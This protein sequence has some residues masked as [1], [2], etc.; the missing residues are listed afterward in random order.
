MTYQ[1]RGSADDVVSLISRLIASVEGANPEFRQYTHDVLGRVGNALLGQV[2]ENFTLKMHRQQGTDGETWVELAPATI[3]RKHLTASAGV[4]HDA[5]ERIART[6]RTI[7]ETV[8][9]RYAT[10]MDHGEARKR[11]ARAAA[12]W[13]AAE[14]RRVNDNLDPEAVDILRETGK[15]LASFAP[16]IDAEPSGAAGQEFEIGDG[17]VAVGSDEKPWHQRGDGVPRRTVW[18]EDGSIPAAWWPA[19][20]TAA[21]NGVSD[22]M[23]LIVQHGRV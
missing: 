23:V 14:W 6:R 17:F 15:M 10:A 13:E 19:L 22:A 20:V 5:A 4:H 11:A 3:A 18:P 7:F 16:G 2:Y 1:S 8:L 12:D 9:A 21:A